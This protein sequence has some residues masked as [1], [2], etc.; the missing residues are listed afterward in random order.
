MLSL[1][2]YYQFK[3]H[4]DLDLNHFMALVLVFLERGTGPLEPQIRSCFRPTSGAF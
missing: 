3:A 1:R 4:L 2:L